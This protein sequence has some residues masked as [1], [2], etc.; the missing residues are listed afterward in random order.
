MIVD[1]SLIRNM[2]DVKSMSMSMCNIWCNAL[3]IGFRIIWALLICS[4]C[5][6]IKQFNFPEVAKIRYIISSCTIVK[7]LDIR[8]MFS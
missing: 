2:N 3:F 6:Y 4:S 5:L 8:L 7:K 1:I